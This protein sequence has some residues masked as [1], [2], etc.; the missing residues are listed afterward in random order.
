MLGLWHWKHLLTRTSLP[1]ASG[2]PGG[3]LRCA[4]AGGERSGAASRAS[5]SFIGGSM[6]LRLDARGAR[7]ARRF[8]ELATEEGAEFLRRRA[9]RLGAVGGEAVP[10]F[11]GA[12]RD[13]R[14]G[15]ESPD[16]GGRR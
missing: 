13:Q 11:L 8:V 4:S 2:K 5:G 15:I 3:A 1:G 6:L 9:E 10:G 12:E 14:L 7:H 16:D